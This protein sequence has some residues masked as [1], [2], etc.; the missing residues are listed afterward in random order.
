[1]VGRNDE[2]HISSGAQ[3]YLVIAGSF[4]T[5]LSLCATGWLCY[6]LYNLIQG[7]AKKFKQDRIIPLFD[8][9]CT[10]A[11]SIFYLVSSIWFLVTVSHNTL[12]LNNMV[13]V[14]LFVVLAKISVYSS[15]LSRQCFQFKNTIHPLLF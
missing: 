9:L 10:I 11:S 14:I 7:M 4:I 8:P 3:F 6:A 12:F 5:L 2:F 1:M 13:W 15:N